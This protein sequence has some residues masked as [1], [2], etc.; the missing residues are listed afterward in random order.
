MSVSLE[1]E[2]ITCNNIED[3]KQVMKK[4]ALAIEELENE[5]F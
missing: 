5:V 3:L 1:S 4:M 2:I